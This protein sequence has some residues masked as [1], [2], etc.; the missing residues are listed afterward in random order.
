MGDKA[1]NL[2]L[3]LSYLLEK[4]ITREQAEKEI[5][6]VARNLATSLY[7]Q[8]IDVESFIA[9]LVH[10]ESIAQ[11]RNIDVSYLENARKRMTGEVSGI[12]KK[13]P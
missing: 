10:I 3:D 7:H 11:A 5:K 8:R 6:Q 1:R 2:H 9:T 4:S 13:A 12:S